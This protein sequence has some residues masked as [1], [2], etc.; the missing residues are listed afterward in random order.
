[1]H[2]INTTDYWNKRFETGGTWEN[3]NGKDQTKYWSKLIVDHLPHYISEDIEI[4]K[5]S[6]ADIGT[7]LGQTAE[8]FKLKFKESKVTGYDFSEIAINRCSILYPEIE[9]RVGSIYEFE[10]VVILSNILEHTYDPKQTLLN[11]LSYTNKYC[12]VL[13]PYKEDSNN[14]IPEHVVSIEE[15]I[16][17]NTIDSFQKVFEKIIDTSH[18]KFW[19]GEA[20]LCVYQHNKT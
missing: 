16:F 18:D 10:D 17:P 8:Y 14:L 9:F 12:I 2:N 19:C 5:L 3:N 15:H 7:A 6:I 11:H 4:N 13:C 20:I 1:M